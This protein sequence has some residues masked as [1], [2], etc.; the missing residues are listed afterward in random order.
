MAASGAA[1]SSRVS[2]T[3]H[4]S[5]R[6]RAQATGARPTS[7]RLAAAAVV[8]AAAVIAGCSLLGSDNPPGQPRIEA[9]SGELPTFT[10]PYAATWAERLPKPPPPLVARLRLNGRNDDEYLYMSDLIQGSGQC[11]VEFVAPGDA[12]A[13]AVYLEPWRCGSPNPK[14]VLNLLVGGGRERG[15]PTL[16]TT[17]TVDASVDELRITFTTSLGDCG[18]STY[19]LD[20]PTMPSAPNRR[21]FMLDMGDCRWGKLEALRAGQVVDTYESYPGAD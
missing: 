15:A 16:I 20:G 8:V 18:S 7:R 5:W 21:A 1:D 13:D 2:A 9:I 3:Q 4:G 11:W 6:T 12:P 10:G 19:P 14:R 17:G